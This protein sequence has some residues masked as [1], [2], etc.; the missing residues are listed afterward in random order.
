MLAVID[1]SNACGQKTDTAE[2]TVSYPLAV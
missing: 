1:S 2:S